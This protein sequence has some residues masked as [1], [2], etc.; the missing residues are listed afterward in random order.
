MPDLSAPERKALAILSKRP[1]LF[2][3]EREALAEIALT[4][5]QRRGLIVACADGWRLT[6]RGRV[7]AAVAPRPE[8]L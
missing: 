3:W 5:L 1:P 2:K 6:E 4:E 8:R 7:R